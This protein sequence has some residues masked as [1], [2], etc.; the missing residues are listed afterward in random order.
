MNWASKVTVATI[1]Q[2]EDKLLMVRELSVDGTLVINQPAGHVEKGETLFQAAIR[3]T[4]EETGIEI[5]LIGVIGIF[6]LPI[7]NNNATYY[8]ILFE[9]KPISS[10]IQPMD[11]DIVS[12]D[13]LPLD[14][15]FEDC[16]KW[17]SPL[18]GKSIN[19]WE[20]REFAPLSFIEDLTIPER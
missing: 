5:D 9:A 14:E 7:T 12:A 16:T 8:R 15:I 6:A 4:K 3:E 10:V 18:V 1:V 20:K 11:P 2:K 17:R 19:A 13:W